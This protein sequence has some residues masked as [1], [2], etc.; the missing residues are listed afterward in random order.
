MAAVPGAQF[1]ASVAQA[2]R[3]RETISFRVGWGRK[4]ARAERALDGAPRTAIFHGQLGSLKLPIR[5]NQLYWLVDCKYS[6]VY[7]NVQSSEGSSDSP[8]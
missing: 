7:Q 5:V 8:L 4:H 3:L 2:K 6:D 1:L